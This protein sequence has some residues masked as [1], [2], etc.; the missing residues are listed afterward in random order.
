MRI[1]VVF[2]AL[3]PTL[4]AGQKLE[5]PGH[6]FK[7]AIS[8]DGQWIFAALLSQ[9]AGDTAGIGVIRR[10]GPD[11]KL[12]RTVRVNPPPRG[13]VLTHD[14]KT[15]I[16][17]NGEGVVFLDV[18]RLI[19]GQGDPEIAVV[20]EDGSPGS[21]Y[22]NVTSDDKTLFISEEGAHAIAVVDVARR[23]IIGTIPVGM[24]P[25]ALTFSPDEK[26]LY[27]TSQGAMPDW[28]WPTVCDSESPQ[29]KAGLRPEGAVIVVDVA[30][31]RADPERSIMTKSHAGCSHVRIAISEKGDRAYVT[32]RKSNAVLVFD[33]EKLVSDPDHAQIGSI[34]VGAAPVP[35]IVIGNRV[36]AGNSNR[37]GTAGSGDQSLTVIDRSN[38]QVTGN[39]PVGQFPRDLIVS[40]DRKTLL[41]ANYGSSTIQTINLP[42]Q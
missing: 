38:M 8:N 42:L 39:I 34:A 37:F 13:I 23:S 31:A 16:A 4:V 35:V 29:S 3:I 36:I 15:L 2:A 14:G 6:P 19:S 26:R 22:V 32:A 1:L 11:L 30:K 27:T 7:L 9:S 41:L 24:A 12:N 18:G 20:K 5:L 21:V 40:P 33:T 10:V 17:S 25:I 28:S